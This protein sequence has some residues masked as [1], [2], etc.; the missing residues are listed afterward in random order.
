MSKTIP[1][2]AQNLRRMNPRAAAIDIVATMHLAAVN[3]DAG[4][5]ESA[6]R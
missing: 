3:P 1:S 5:Q 4:S 6:V 2:N